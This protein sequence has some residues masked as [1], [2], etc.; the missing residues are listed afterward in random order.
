[1]RHWCEKDF[2]LRKLLTINFFTK[3]M[4]V[5]VKNLSS[6]HVYMS[7]SVLNSK[8]SVRNCTRVC[9]KSCYNLPELEWEFCYYCDL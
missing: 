7:V 1:M 9:N 3:F 5:A 4:V 8:E 6:Q 2:F